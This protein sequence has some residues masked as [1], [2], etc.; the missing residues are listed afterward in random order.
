MTGCLCQCLKVFHCLMLKINVSSYK[1]VM[2]RN[3]SL[4]DIPGRCIEHCGT[5]ESS[6]FVCNIQTN[7]RCE[8]RTGISVQKSLWLLFLQFRL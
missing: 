4:V 7:Q 8:F 3:K 1:K 2:R 5:I 6:L